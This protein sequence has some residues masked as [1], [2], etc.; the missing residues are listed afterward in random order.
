MHTAIKQCQIT[1]AATNDINWE[2]WLWTIF[3]SSL[4]VDILE[5]V[6]G[7]TKDADNANL[8]IAYYINTRPCV[9]LFMY[10]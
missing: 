8:C 4:H 9:N 1:I 5:N 10:Y 7:E 3:V 2:A 6:C